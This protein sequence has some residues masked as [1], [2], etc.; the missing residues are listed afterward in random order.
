MEGSPTKRRKEVARSASATSTVLAQGELS[1]KTEDTTAFI[2]K[3]V[4]STRR[5]E[6]ASQDAQ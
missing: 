5:Q 1:V 4:I 2:G 3:I 6:T